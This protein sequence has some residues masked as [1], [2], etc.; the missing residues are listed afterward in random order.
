LLPQWVQ[1]LAMLVAPFRS[2]AT[3]SSLMM[4]SAYV[5]QMAPG[6]RIVVA[7]TFQ[8]GDEARR[9]ERLA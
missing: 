5:A 1:T 7:A 6:G 4:I 8:A 2:P 9:V 3:P